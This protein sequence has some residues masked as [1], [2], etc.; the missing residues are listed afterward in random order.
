MIRTFVHLDSATIGSALESQ[1]RSTNTGLAPVDCNIYLATFNPIVFGHA[2][3]LLGKNPNRFGYDLS[4]YLA[5]LEL[6]FRRKPQEGF[7]T[8]NSGSS[9]FKKRLAEDIG[10]G[11]AALFMVMSFEIGWETI[12]QIPQ[13]RKLSKYTPDFLGLTKNDE[14]FIFEAK[15]TTQPG[16]VEGAMSKALTQAKSYPEEAVNK[17][18]I[19]SY[20]PSSVKQV[21]PVT[22]VAD[23]AISD[24]FPPGRENS[25]LLHYA[26]VLEYAGLAQTRAA[27]EHLL[28]IGFDIERKESGAMHSAYKPYLLRGPI[29]EIQTVFSS[30]V[31]EE[32]R[33]SWRDRMFVGWRRSASR[34]DER[35]SIFLGV[36]EKYISRILQL[37][38]DIPASEDV[39]VEDEREIAS[40]FSDGT[41]LRITTEDLNERG[42]NRV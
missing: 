27:Y 6:F 19:V 1:I 30:E 35:L 2:S 32:N 28:S 22:F 5:T 3:L 10:A 33:L 13:N 26:K 25:T 7:L 12:S 31:G 42:L 17:F 36:D 8:I 40:V 18:A 34:R 9:D 41:I 24:T 29:N 11:L 15:G 4:T 37:E 16:A 14:R 20:F 23:P 39:H 21:P 38:T